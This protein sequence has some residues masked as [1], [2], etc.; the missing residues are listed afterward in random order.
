M[1]CFM[2]GICEFQSHLPLLRLT[3]GVDLRP[4]SGITKYHMNQ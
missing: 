3:E 2:P 4:F 1:T